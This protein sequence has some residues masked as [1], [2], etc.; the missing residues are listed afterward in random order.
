MNTLMEAAI[1]FLRRDASDYNTLHRLQ[2]GEQMLTRD[3]VADL[4]V[5]TPS[6]APEQ[7]NV[8][9]LFDLMR[10]AASWGMVYGPHLTGDN[11]HKTRDEFIRNTLGSEKSPPDW[12]R[13]KVFNEMKERLALPSNDEASLGPWETLHDLNRAAHHSV[14][15]ASPGEA[16]THADGLRFRRIVALLAE[17]WRH[18]ELQTGDDHPTMKRAKEITDPILDALDDNDDPTITMAGLPQIVRDVIDQLWREGLAP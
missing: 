4:L 12:M 14:N 17:V 9:P 13:I 11:W 7:E 18:D 8:S 1:K 2:V 3:Q 6:V 16:E 15:Y 5:I 10:S